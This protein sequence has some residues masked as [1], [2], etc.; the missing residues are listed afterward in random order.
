MQKFFFI[1]IGLIPLII[2]GTRCQKSIRKEGEIKANSTVQDTTEKEYYE[3]AS[4]YHLKGEY[5]KAVKYYGKVISLNPDF[6]IA[7]YDRGGVYYQLG[8]YQKAI[9]DYKFVIKKTLK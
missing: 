6:I 1:I 5:R 9:K 2:M 4:S 3:L 8:Y 7:Y